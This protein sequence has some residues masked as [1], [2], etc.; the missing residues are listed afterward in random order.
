M[1]TTDTVNKILAIIDKSILLGAAYDCM[2]ES[3]KQKF[4]DKLTKIINEH[5]TNDTGN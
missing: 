3:G 2:S 4:I 5:S 1:S